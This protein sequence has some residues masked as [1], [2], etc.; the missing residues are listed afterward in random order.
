MQVESVGVH[1]IFPKSIDRHGNIPRHIGKQ[2]T[3]LSSALKALSY[4][5]K[6]VKIGSVYPKIFD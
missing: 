2:G 6:V 3:D 5:E 4:G 1:N